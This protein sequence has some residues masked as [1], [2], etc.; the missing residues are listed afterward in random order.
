M[1]GDGAFFTEKP[2][3]H[4]PVQCNTG[5]RKLEPVSTQPLV[6]RRSLSVNKQEGRCARRIPVPDTRCVRIVRPRHNR[7]DETMALSQSS[8]RP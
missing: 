2:K 8:P 1:R 7:R 3:C 4:H 5:E 6:E